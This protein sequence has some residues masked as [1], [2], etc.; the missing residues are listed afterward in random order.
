M[1]NYRGF[2]LYELLLFII[3][4]AL[5]ANT[6]IISLF[7]T[8]RKIP[9]NNNGFLATEIASRCLESLITQRR[10]SGYNAPFNTCSSS[11]LTSSIPVDCAST[12]NSYTVSV[13]NVC[14][15]ILS[16]DASQSSVLTVT[17]SGSTSDTLTM[18]ITAY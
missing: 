16:G 13:Q 18:L 10:T 1:T 15:P 5:V 2:T 17:A 8:V 7:E 12:I 3:V 4:S 9:I 6:I 11:V 14:G